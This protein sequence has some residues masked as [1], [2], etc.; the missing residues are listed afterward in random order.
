MPKL[1][2]WDSTFQLATVAWSIV[3]KYWA[4]SI[5]IRS[6]QINFSLLQHSTVCSTLTWILERTMSAVFCMWISGS[7]LWWICFP[8]ISFFWFSSGKRWIILRG[9]LHC[10]DP[11]SKAITVALYV[12]ISVRKWAYLLDFFVFLFLC[13]LRKELSIK[14]YQQSCSFHPPSQCLV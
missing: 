9:F 1:Q 5:A 4:L 11:T 8:R 10:L 14:I 2:G 6:F 3:K 13:Y 12:L 7:Y